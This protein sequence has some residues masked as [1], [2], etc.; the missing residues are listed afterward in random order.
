ME[1]RKS[2]QFFL[3]FIVDC[4][5]LIISNLIAALICIIIKKMP[6]S[7]FHAYVLYVF[8]LFVS[9]F[10]IFFGFSRS[11]DLS[12]RSRSAELIRVVRNCLLTY[13]TFAVMLVFTRNDLIEGRYLFVIALILFIALSSVNRYMLKRYLM[14]RFRKSKMV[15]LTCVITV[16]N[17]AEKFIEA[18]QGDWSRKI[19]GVAVLDSVS[20]ENKTYK[21]YKKAKESAAVKGNVIQAEKL[22]YSEDV[23]GIPIKANED[24]LIDW[25]LSSALDE[26]FIKL[27]LNSDYDVSG[28]IEKLE[29]MGL[30]VHTNIPTI[31]N[32][33]EK[34]GFDNISCSMIAGSPNVTLTA[35]KPMP[36]SLFVIKRVIDIAGGLIGTVLSAP[37]IAVV[38]VPLLIESP[39]PLIF[40]QQRV[41][42]NG[43]IFNIYKLRSMCVNAENLKK[44]LM[45]ENKMEGFMFKMDDDPRITKVGK[46]I[47]RTSIDELPQFWNVLKGDMSLVGTRPP[48]VDEFEQYEIHHKRRLSMKPGIT[49]MWQVSGR[50]GIQNFEDVVKLDVEYINKWSPWLDIKILIKTVGVVLCKNGAE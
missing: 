8:C 41:G 13:M 40:K 24:N 7:D 50:S 10:V 21:I 36:F 25:V 18:L 6:N 12:E 39:G 49:G 45:N 46:F 19:I 33:V 43:R 2:I 47:R 17:Y 27:P 16:S 3:E 34:S 1:K 5:A 15:T 29:N 31:E 22:S 23:F 20:D 48:T 30:I 35:S 26:V 4:F 42:K 37:V 32:L 11:L 9:Y 38:A 44:D 28:L 14:R